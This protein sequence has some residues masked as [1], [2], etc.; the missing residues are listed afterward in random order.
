M[1]FKS[2]GKIRKCKWCD[3]PAKKVHYC[4]FGKGEKYKK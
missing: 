3:K 1:P 2:S 4:W